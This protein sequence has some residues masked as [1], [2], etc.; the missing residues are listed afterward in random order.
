MSLSIAQYDDDAAY[1]VIN[2]ADDISQVDLNS[3]GNAPEIIKEMR[4]ETIEIILRQ[5]KAPGEKVVK[6]ARVNDRPPL[7]M[8]RGYATLLRFL[9]GS[10]LIDLEKKLGF[11]NGALQ[12]KGAYLYEVDPTSLNAAT[13][14]PRGNTD[15]SA[16]VTPRDLYNLST[17]YGVNVG[18]NKNYPSA[19]QPI[20]QFLIL[21]DVPLLG[22]PRLIKLGEIV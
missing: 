21:R 2:N 15:W 7:G 8:V 19:E 5:A 14:V 10:N 16:G 20:I 1:Y 11:K 18:Y 4:R 22:Q 6:I 9:K 12:S 17:R 13:I 3:V